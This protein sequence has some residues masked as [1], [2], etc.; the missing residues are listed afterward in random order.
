MDLAGKVCLVTG[1]TRGIGAATALNFAQAGASLVLVARR[2]DDAAAK[3]RATI[4]ALGGRCVSVS[5]DLARPEV[6]TQCVERSVQEFGGVDVLV[7]SAGGPA[8]GG[9]LA[10]QPSDWYGAFDIHVHAIFHLC[11]AAIPHMQKRG[12]GVI[13][14]IS[15]AAGIRGLKTNVA[16][17]AVKGVL[18]QL[19]RALA[20][21]FAG[22]NI[23]VNCVAPGVIRTDFHASMP[24]EVKELNLNQRIPMRREGTPAQVATLI[25]ELVTNEYITGETVSIDG[26]LTM[27]IC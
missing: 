7:H 8:P 14:L 19:T 15:S 10:L 11:R 5:G 21:E 3:T 12:Q 26:G 23:R 1:G 16:Y 22:Q 27:R 25:R 18:P 13:I 2:S 20:F 9:L 4:E 6:A 17:Q 24:P